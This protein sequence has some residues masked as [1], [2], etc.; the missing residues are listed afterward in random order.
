MHWVG[1]GR[2]SWCGCSRS[3]RIQPP[4][5]WRTEQTQLRLRPGLLL[6]CG[7]TADQRRAGQGVDGR[8]EVRSPVMGHLVAA[9]LAEMAAGARPGGFPAS[10]CV[11]LC[12]C[13]HRCAIHGGAG[14]CA[15]VRPQQATATLRVAGS[16][17]AGLFCVQI[18]LAECCNP[19]GSYKAIRPVSLALCGLG[20]WLR[21]WLLSCS[22]CHL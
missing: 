19:K 22:A 11:M 15:C 20:A 12:G 6:F 2:A 14:Y 5:G 9:T 8:P 3:E 1:V 17:R 4:A 10:G 7:H 16:W 21:L 13:C 18:G